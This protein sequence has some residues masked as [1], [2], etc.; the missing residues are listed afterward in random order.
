MI[1]V[2]YPTVVEKNGLLFPFMFLGNPYFMILI[3][4]DSDVVLSISFG[5]LKWVASLHMVLEKSSSREL[6]LLFS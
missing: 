3:R 1:V 2:K 4:G 6:T 5:G